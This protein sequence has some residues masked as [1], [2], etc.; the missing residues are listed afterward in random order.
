MPVTRHPPHRS[1]HAELPHWAP[2]SGNDAQTVL[3]PAVSCQ[4]HVYKVP[5][6]CV[7]SLFCLTD[8]PWPAYFSPPPPPYACCHVFCSKASSILL[9]CPTSVNHSY[10]SYG[11]SPSLAVPHIHR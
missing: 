1:Q 10:Q 9:S 6:P 4:T 11:F 7:R 2:A 3:L 8:S 5:R